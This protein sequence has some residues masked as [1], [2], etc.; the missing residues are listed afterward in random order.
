MFANRGVL[1]LLYTVPSSCFI[2][3]GGVSALAAEANTT[4]PKRQT[5]VAR[6]ATD[7]M[8]DC[9]RPLF[10]HMMEYAAAAERDVVDMVSGNPD[11]EAPAAVR[12]GLAAYADADV[13][14]FQYP[15]SEGLRELREEIAARRNVDAERVI[16][17]NGAGEANYLATACALEAADGDEVLLTDPVYPY[18]QGRAKMLGATPRFVEAEPDGTLDP[19][20]VRAASSSHSGRTA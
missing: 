6:A 5:D 1:Y 12:S 17:T 4:A 8:D 16:V 15:P 9:D 3:D 19:A 20:A 14:R 18:Y 2:K 7:G 10:F 11:W 13:E